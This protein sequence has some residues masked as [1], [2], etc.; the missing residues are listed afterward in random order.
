MK[1]LPQLTEKRVLRKLLKKSFGQNNNY[2]SVSIK[3]FFENIKDNWYIILIIIFLIII[4]IHLYID[5]N[6]KKEL[7]KMEEFKKQISNKE[8]EIEDFKGSYESEYYKMLPRVTNSPHVIPY[9]Y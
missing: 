5:N 1:V 4:F 9:Q 8:N 2:L 3:H 6:K 7:E